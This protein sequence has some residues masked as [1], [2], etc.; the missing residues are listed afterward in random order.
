MRSMLNRL[1]RAFLVALVTL[2][3]LQGYAAATAIA[4]PMPHARPA[5]STTAP[6]AMPCHEA[7]ADPAAPEPP[8]DGCASCA[9]F[10]SVAIATVIPEATVVLPSAAPIAFNGFAHREVAPQALERPPR[11]AFA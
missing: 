8:C 6:A 10:S 11:T 4:C 9:A 3:P 5:A 2:L 7:P 1:R